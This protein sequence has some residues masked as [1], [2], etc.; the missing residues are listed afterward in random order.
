MTWLI[1]I[2]KTMNV[3]GMGWK[4]RKLKLEFPHYVL[5]TKVV[6]FCSIM[7]DCKSDWKCMFINCAICNCKSNFS[8]QIGNSPI[9]IVKDCWHSLIAN[10]SLKKGISL[11]I[12]YTQREF[13][14]FNFII[15]LVRLILNNWKEDNVTPGLCIIKSPENIFSFVHLELDH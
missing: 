8:F 11:I 13:L 15:K 6:K 4:Y 3:K 9:W 1:W 10:L 5:M 2:D 14:P 12:S 7:K